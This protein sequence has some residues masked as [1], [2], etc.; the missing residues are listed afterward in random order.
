MNKLQQLEMRIARLEKQSGRQAK[1][2][3]LSATLKYVK[4]VKTDRGPETS[5]VTDNVLYAPKNSFMPEMSYSSIHTFPR[6]I[7]GEVMP[8]IRDLQ[9]A[10][11]K[12]YHSG[13][14]PSVSF[15]QSFKNSGNTF[16]WRYHTNVDSKNTILLQYSRT[17]A[18]ASS[19]QAP[20]IEIQVLNNRGK[21]VNA[22]RFIQSV[23][24]EL[25]LRTISPR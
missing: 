8:V 19:Y 17:D 3:S 15:I 7:S 13:F 24:A 23:A 22:T 16:E 12:V 21:V 4:R 18:R 10:V 14:D 20:S 11:E 5:F 1:P 2:Y 6:F 25:N 9:D